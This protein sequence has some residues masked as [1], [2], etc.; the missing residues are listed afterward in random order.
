MAGGPFAAKGTT[1]GRTIDVL[2]RQLAQARA[3]RD[4]AQAQKAAL[5]EVL[6]AINATPADFQPVFEMIIA[7]AMELCEAAFG[8]LLGCEQDHLYLLAH[9]NGPPPLV[10]FWQTPQ[11]VHP[12]TGTHRALTGGKPIHVAD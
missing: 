1:E 3:E 12:E 5:A 2:R 11:P 7:K 8:S 10:E 4:E 9:I 6:R